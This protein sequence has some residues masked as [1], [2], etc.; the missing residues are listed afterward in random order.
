MCVL[1][2]R[3][4]RAEAAGVSRRDGLA[5]VHGFLSSCVDWGALMNEKYKVAAYCRPRTGTWRWSALDLNSCLVN[6]QG[7]L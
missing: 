5:H 3:L 6:L 1:S 7:E 4:G 2:R